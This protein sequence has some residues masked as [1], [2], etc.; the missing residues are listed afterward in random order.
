MD[1]SLNGYIQFAL[2][3][4]LGSCGCD[5]EA[6]ES[7]AVLTLAKKNNSLMSSCAHKGIVGLALVA[8]GRDSEYSE[9]GINKALFSFFTQHKFRR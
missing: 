6:V 4:L 9:K 7:G 8:R 5:S 3:T 1:V 2:R